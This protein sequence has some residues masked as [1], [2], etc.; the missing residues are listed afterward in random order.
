M[1]PDWERLEPHP[2][3][4]PFRKGECDRCPE[5]GEWGIPFPPGIIS[6]IKIILHDLGKK[7]GPQQGENKNREG[8][9]H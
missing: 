2:V 6:I 3:S 5:G 7:A 8:S 4:V 9:L 1:P